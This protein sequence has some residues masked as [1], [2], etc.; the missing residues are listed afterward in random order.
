MLFQTDLFCNTPPPKVKKYDTKTSKSEFIFIGRANFSQQLAY[1]V[2]CLFLLYILCNESDLLT[3]TTAVQINQTLFYDYSTFYMLTCFYTLCVLSHLS[4]RCVN[5]RWQDTAS[6]WVQSQVE[7]NAKLAV[8]G[9]QASPVLRQRSDRRV[10]YFTASHPGSRS[11]FLSN[12]SACVC[13]NFTHKCTDDLRPGV[14]SL[15]CRII[16][17][18][19]EEWRGNKKKKCFYFIF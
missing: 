6:G 16:V 15:K 11:C 4:W 1:T 14:K 13:G 10:S 7:A 8:D 2:A 17:T 18:E 19:S 9:Q 3:E 12:K 5:F